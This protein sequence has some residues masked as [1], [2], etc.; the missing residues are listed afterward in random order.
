MTIECYLVVVKK[1]GKEAKVARVT[2]ARPSLSYN[3]ALIKLSLDV[4]ADIFEAPLIT[5]P[6][7]RRQVAVAVEV[8]EV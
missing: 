2:Q 7:E 4:P 8:D 5:V 1:R 3:E 6:V